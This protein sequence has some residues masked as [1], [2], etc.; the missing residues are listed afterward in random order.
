MKICSQTKKLLFIEFT[1]VVVAESFLQNV[2]SKYER[3]SYIGAFWCPLEVKIGDEVIWTNPVPGSI[4]Y[5]RPVCL[6]RGKEEREI[7]LN[8]FKPILRA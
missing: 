8:H 7:V 4:S 1:L 3:G 2:L 6:L 5:T